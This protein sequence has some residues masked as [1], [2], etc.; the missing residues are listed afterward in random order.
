MLTVRSLTLDVTAHPLRIRKFAVATWDLAL[1]ST[2]AC[3][4]NALIASQLPLQTQMLSEPRHRQWFRRCT[5]CAVLQHGLPW[6][7]R[8]AAHLQWHVLLLCLATHCPRRTTTPWLCCQG[9]SIR[10]AMSIQYW[11]YSKNQN[12][13]N[14][15]SNMQTEELQPAILKDMH[16][17][18]LQ[19]SL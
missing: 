7:V 5:A 3:S 10:T 13:H 2:G 16:N 1:K 14:M 15:Q 9:Q 4:G 18:S 8:P 12:N 17:L 6:T 19:T 11:Q